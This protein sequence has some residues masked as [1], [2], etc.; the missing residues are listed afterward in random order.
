MKKKIVLGSLFGDE[1]KGTVVQWLCKEAIA[2]NKSCIVVR[3]CGGPQAGHTVTHNGITHEFSSFGSGTL[4]GV[5]TYIAEN[6]LVDP[7]CL[8]KEW[9]VLLDK[10]IEPEFR[11]SSFCRIITPYDVIHARGDEKTL[12]D[13]TTGHGV[14][15]AVIRNEDFPTYFSDRNPEDML[16]NSREY[17]SLEKD[18]ELEELFI[19]CYNRIKDFYYTKMCS[20]DVL[21]YEGTQGL[22]LDAERGFYPNVTATK[23]GLNALDEET[24]KDAEVYFVTRTY[25]TRHGNGFKPVSHP[26]IKENESNHTNEFQ[27][28]FKT[29]LFEF[30]ILNAAF[31]RHCLD[32]YVRKYNL[33]INLV[34]THLDIPKITYWYID[35]CQSYRSTEVDVNSI[36]KVFE[37]NI[38][39]NIKNFYYSD[40]NI[41]NIKKFIL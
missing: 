21:I 3:Y 6:V 1:G 20:S 34:V 33:N 11:I 26:F 5:P 15:A 14:Y 2:D 23:V 29:G 9:D 37:N 38:N 22:L 17:Y 7:I 18:E 25:L 28:E 35:K 19:S 30:P 41:S 31:Q 8:C 12:Q 4:L 16:R 13:G 36:M 39:F 27:G 10:G 24:L 32:N 40:N